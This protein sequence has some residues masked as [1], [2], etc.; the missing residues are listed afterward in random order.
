MEWQLSRQT[1]VS[2]ERHCERSM[3][4]AIS[5]NGWDCFVPRNDRWRQQLQTKPSQNYAIG[6]VCANIF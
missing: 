6:R 1:K 3:S 5:I 4:A 2:A